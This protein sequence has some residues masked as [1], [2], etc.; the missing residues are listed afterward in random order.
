MWRHACRSLVSL[1]YITTRNIKLGSEYL[2]IDM[3]EVKCHI[4][5]WCST[6]DSMG[7]LC[8]ADE[9]VAESVRHQGHRIA[10]IDQ[11]AC[12]STHRLESYLQSLDF[13]LCE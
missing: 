9:V 8:A 1:L 7:V 12:P 3:G 5:L 10:I 6:V 11:E 2:H 4:K 13:S